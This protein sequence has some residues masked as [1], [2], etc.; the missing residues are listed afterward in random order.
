MGGSKFSNLYPP[1]NFHLGSDFGN[2]IVT[3]HFPP[4]VV[5]PLVLGDFPLLHSSD[6]FVN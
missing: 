1:V 4:P 2:E 3:S 6:D 5:L